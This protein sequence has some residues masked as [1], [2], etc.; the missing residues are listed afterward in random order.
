MVV[1]QS[2]PIPKEPTRPSEAER[3]LAAMREML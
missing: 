1:L 3:E 2:R